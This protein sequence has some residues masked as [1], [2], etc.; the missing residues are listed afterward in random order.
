[1]AVFALAC[2]AAAQEHAV[3]DA[4][5]RLNHFIYDGGELAAQT[6]VAA[7]F[8][9]RARIVTL[10]GEPER[11][12][13][14]TAW[15]GTVN[16]DSGVRARIRQT[17]TDRDGKIEVAVEVTAES[18]FKA[19]GLY[20]VIETPWA[21]FNGGKAE[22]GGAVALPAV[23]PPGDA[24]AGATT[25]TVKL[26]GPER[27]LTLA[28][29]L[30]G[31]HAVT[32]RDE[33]QKTGHVY[34]V[35]IEFQ[36]GTLAAGAKAATT[37]TLSLAGQA[38]HSPATVAV[39]TAKARYKFQGFGGNYCWNPQDPATAYT[40]ENLDPRWARVHMA[41]LDW[42]PARAAGDR[43]GTSLHR[44]LELAQKIQKLG[45]PYIISIWQI[46]VTV[47]AEEER[48]PDEHGQRVGLTKWDELLDSI[49]SYLLY[50]KKQYGVEPDFFSFN[51]ANIGVNLLLTPAEHREEIKA[52]GRYFEK[53]GLK[54]R[55]L[56]GDVNEPGRNTLAW[57]LAAAN[58][59]EIRRYAGVVSMHSW[60]GGTPEEYAAWG[61]LASWLGLPLVVAEF[62]VDPF[63]WQ[64][65]SFDSHDYGLRELRM[66]QELLEYA[67]PQ[68]ILYWEYTGD[69]GLVRENGAAV[70]PTSRYWM[71]K[72]LASLTPHDAD[73]FG[74]SS[75][76][77]DVLA[78]VFGRGGV[79]ALH[80]ANLGASRTI[81]VEGLPAAAGWRVVRTSETE[82][83]AELAPAGARNGSV[84]IEAPA[85]C[86]L[87]VTNAPK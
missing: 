68:V 44:A 58:D 43:P 15:S 39:S 26:L 34:S 17:V 30:D 28:A 23:R 85:R 81:T 84:K 49:G 62:G 22:L 78:T 9:G 1:M 11:Q 5:G 79:Y 10:S 41:L 75:D 73:A 69:Y 51:E 24:V 6:R 71:V 53:L 63:A 38:D 16:P 65:R 12:N 4:D 36:H 19:D 57:T 54:T 64:V 18:D 70:T 46:P 42:E 27:G 82:G 25:S 61:D 83:M 29:A 8:R 74:A 72:Q 47:A 33:W 86:L 31:P 2:A 13:L 66:F 55:M 48:P 59:P 45:I 3:F 20:F 35:W 21:E 87:T 52:M 76:N 56:L 37:V 77:K 40:L 67:R 14:G 32:L 60:N 7:T 50:A 80:I